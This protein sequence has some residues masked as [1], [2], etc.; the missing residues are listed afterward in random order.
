MSRGTLGATQEYYDRF[1]ETYDCGRDAGY[2]R[3]VDELELGIL[4]RYATGR[5]VVEAG[6]GTGLLLR[7]VA[8]FARSAVGV[9]LSRGMLAAARARGLH[10]V[11][12]SLTDLPLPGASADLIYSMK[13][14]PHVAPIREALRELARVLRP[15]GH[16]VAEFY[17]PWSLRSLAKRVA[18]PGRVATGVR[19]S[20]VFTRFDTLDEARAHL[21]DDLRLVDVRGVRIVT[22][23]AAMHRW[24]LAGALL[25][26]AERALCDVPGVRRLAGFLVLVARKIDP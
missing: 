26:R 5:E 3:L 4:R 17:N 25:G 11:Q 18:G 13:V 6:C 24:P 7:E 9:D 12:G 21:P 1:A 15:G 10:V 22:P 19:E 20:D 14:L 2:H 23:Y 16:L 8:G